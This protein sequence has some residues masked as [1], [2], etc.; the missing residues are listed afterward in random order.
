MLNF[1]ILLKTLINIRHNNPIISNDGDF[2]F[3]DHNELLIYKREK[4]NNIY[5]VVIN[6]KEYAI[7]TVLPWDYDTVNIIN[8]DVIGKYIHMNRLGFM[9]LYKN[10]E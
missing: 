8:N 5:Y 2:K 3:I 7:D 6:S 9:I 10:K 4:D 1:L